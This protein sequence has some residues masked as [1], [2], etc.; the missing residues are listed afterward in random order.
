MLNYRFEEI[1]MKD[2][3]TFNEFYTKLNYI[4]NCNF[5]IGEKIPEQRI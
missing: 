3:E 2:D 5:N 1:R 4:V